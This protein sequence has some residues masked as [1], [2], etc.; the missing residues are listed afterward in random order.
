M[1]STET[2]QVHSSLRPA[3]RASDESVVEPLMIPLVVIVIGELSNGSAQM[4]LAER[5]D[6]R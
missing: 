6:L 4:L 1:V 3:P 5:N 2:G